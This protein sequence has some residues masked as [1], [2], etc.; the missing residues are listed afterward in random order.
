MLPLE[1]DLRNIFERKIKEAREIAEEA[2]KVAIRNLGV[3]EASPYNY[4]TDTERIL[5]RKLRARGRQLGDKRDNHYHT[6]EINMLV[7]EVAYEHWHRM[8]FARFLAENQLLMYPD[9]DDPV[10]IT[11]EECEDLAKDEGAKNGWDLAARY[12]AQMLPQIFRPDSPVFEIEFPI[13]Y[14]SRLESLLVELPKDIFSATDSLGW[15]YQFWQAKKKEEINAS[16]VKVG[17]KELP[18]VTQLFTEPYMVNFLLENSLGAW[19]ASKKLREKSSNDCINEE[20]VRKELSLQNIPFDYLRLTKNEDLMWDVVSKSYKG[21]PKDLSQLKILDPCCGSGHFLVSSLLLLVPIRMEEEE[22]SAQE[23]VDLVLR[24]NLYGLDIDKRVVEIAVFSLALTAWRYPNAGGYRKLPE[25][26]I[27]CSGL[28]ISI[29]KEEWVGLAGGDTSFS[30]YLEQLYNMFKNAPSIG[31]LINP[32]NILT[33][34]TIFSDDL[35]KIKMLLEKSLSNKNNIESTEMGVVAKGLAKAASIL[36]MKFNL[37]I[38]NVPFKETKQLD[39]NIRQYIEEYYVKGKVN[40]ATAFILRINDWLAKGGNASIVTPHEWL[41]LGSYKKIRI[42][43][44]KNSI[45][46]TFVDLGEQAFESPQ[47]AGAFTALISF[48]KG[49]PNENTD[50]MGLDL[51]KIKSASEKSISIKNND[52]SMYNQLEQLNNPDSRIGLFERSDLPLLSKFA[53]SYVGLQNGD[54]PKYIHYFWEA[55]MPSDIWTYFQLPCDTTGD[56]RGKEGILR[57]ENGNGDLVRSPQAYIKGKEAWGKQGVAIRQTRLLPATLYNGHLYDQSS[58]VIVPFND[59]H[60]PA[61]WAFCSSEV[62]HEEVRKID[63]KKNVTNATLVKIPIDIEYWDNVAKNL[64]QN[65]LPKPYSNDPTQWIFHGHP[66]NSTNPLQVA[67]ARLLGYQWPSEI[68]EGIELS[69][70]SKYWIGKSKDLSQFADQDGIVCLPSVIGELPAV[71]RLLNLLIEAYGDQWTNGKLSQLLGNVG[72][73]GKTLETWLRD[74][75]FTQHCKMFEN[76]PFVWHIWDGLSDGFSAL[77]NYQMLDRNLLERLIYTYLGDWIKKQKNDIA[78]KIDGAQEKL[79]AAENLKKQLELILE[80][81]AP[82]DIFVRWK[83]IEN[84]PIGWKPDINDGVRLNIRPFMKVSDIG[85]KGAGILR[86]KPN[87]NWKKDRGKDIET[88]PWYHFFNGERV[89]DYHLT[90]SDKMEARRKR[91]EDL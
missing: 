29:K 50:F 58:A 62:F 71:D 63:K 70:E 88:A 80:G 75:F 33:E 84:Q 57:W 12:A 91:K 2:A 8:L 19:W 41:F 35:E 74:K 69:K 16:E 13:E 42:E 6:Q 22:I 1:K 40:L 55:K 78:E 85:K 54:A 31:S 73:S 67:V 18:A 4:L 3:G 49:K 65:G 38:T 53:G 27:A 87:I 17:A 30:Y 36:S 60:L 90:L 34:N 32:E 45:W 81:E 56:F 82:Y 20:E 76:R 11:L 66:V 21:W 39:D 23:A 5:R 59:E 48:S 61:I 86:D 79:E 51:T 7:E 28:S 89:N 77:I 10:A 9:P 68:D 72:H 43:L 24:E 83:S 52:I 46:N 25:L 37:I 26:N 44:L 47:A 14:Q 15:V 64:Y